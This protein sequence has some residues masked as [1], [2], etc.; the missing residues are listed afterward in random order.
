MKKCKKC[1]S[2]I[3]PKKNATNAIYC[4]PTCRPVP[5]QPWTAN[6]SL[7]GAYNEHLVVADLMRHS[8]SVFRAV[9]PSSPCDLIAIHLGVP[10]RI[11][12]T[13]GFRRT[14]GGMSWNRHDE[15]NYDVM[16]LVFPDN[17][18][19]YVVSPMSG[20]ASASKLPIFPKCDPAPECD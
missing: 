17:S 9:A 13:R 4:G 12:V 5:H 20:A 7:C 16:A 8:L 2:Q 18:I 15:A 11:E 14:D 6:T 3:A 19:V 10:Y 1:G